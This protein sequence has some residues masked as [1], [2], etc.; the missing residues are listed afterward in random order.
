MADLSRVQV[1]RFMLY[2]FFMTNCC[3]YYVCIVVKIENS[4][5]VASGKYKWVL[6]IVSTPQNWTV[7]GFSGLSLLTDVFWNWRRV[8]PVSYLTRL[9]RAAGCT[10]LPAESV[11]CCCHSRP[12]KPGHC[13][14]V[15]RSWRWSF[16]SL[17]KKDNKEPFISRTWVEIPIEYYFEM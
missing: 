13:S 15:T 17:K 9:D 5:K 14:A 8:S 16:W 7:A 11:G 4:D 12:L 6:D 1:L 2:F 10:A 3:V